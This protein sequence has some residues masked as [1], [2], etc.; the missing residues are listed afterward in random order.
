MSVRTTRTA[1]ASGW[2]VT[3][4]PDGVT[5][6]RV[7]SGESATSVRSITGIVLALAG[8]GL[9]VPVVAQMI[10]AVA[11]AVR[12]RPETFASY[13]SA[14]MAYQYP[15]GM[16][17]AHLG[18]AMLIP[19]SL[20][21]VRYV[22]TRSTRFLHSVQPGVRWRY[23]LVAAVAAVVVLNAV[24]WISRIGTATTWAPQAHVG[25][26]LLLIV[27]TSPWQAAAEEYFFR[28]YLMQALGSIV[29]TPWFGVVTSALVFAIFHGVQN[30]ALFV[31]RF[32][33]GLL[34]GTLVLVTGGLEAG[35]AA[36]V[37]NNIFAFGYAALMG[38][39]ATARGVTTIT[40]AGAGWD[41]LG[42][43]LFGAVAWWLGR[44]FN[45]ATTTPGEGAG[46]GLG[47]RAGIH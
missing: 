10:L 35:I 12:G 3:P 16:L 13:Y 19:V 38:G 39:V 17:G 30:P 33:F 6:P 44:R 4:T 15:E 42:F 25:W 31:D 34:A 45:L 21:V 41:L 47:V 46:A 43:A 2:P 36:H 5:Y 27:V 7:L 26:W 18:L 1:P 8:Y 22:H 37:V 23:L 20:L 24:L 14:A 40:W 32:G 29:P 28:G 11:W 9:V